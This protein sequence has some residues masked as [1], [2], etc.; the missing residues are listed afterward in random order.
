[1]YGGGGQAPKPTESGI[2]AAGRPR[3]RALHICMCAR[4]ARARV[5]VYYTQSLER[6]FERVSEIGRGHVLEKGSFCFGLCCGEEDSRVRLR[7]AVLCTRGQQSLNNIVCDLDLTF[8][9]CTYTGFL[10]TS[11]GA[12]LYTLFETD[13]SALITMRESEEKNWILCRT[14]RRRSFRNRLFVLC[15]SATGL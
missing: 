10:R 13:R 4:R 6:G 9:V 5:C 7:R 12:C 11:S 15:L 2:E 3:P 8:Y 14:M 1:M